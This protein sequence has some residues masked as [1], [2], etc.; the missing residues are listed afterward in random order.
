MKQS[1][2]ALFSRNEDS[3]LAILIALVFL[4]TSYHH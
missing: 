3:A 1:F 2:R 4:L